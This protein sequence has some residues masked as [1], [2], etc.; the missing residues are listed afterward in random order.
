VLA[1]AAA[2]RAPVLAVVRTNEV[3]LVDTSSPLHPARSEPRA[4]PQAVRDAEVVAADVSPDG[5]LLAIATEA[6]N[7]VV[8]LDLGP[9]GHTPV[10]GML[11]VA[12][13]VRESVLADLAF[14]PGGDTLWVLS[15]DTPRS[16]AVGP[17]P[18]ELR[19]VRLRSDAQSMANLTAARVVEVAEAAA[20]VRLGVGRA[21]PLASG[22]AIRLPPERNT[23]FFAATAHPGSS[24][25]IFRVGAE[26]A[27]TVA[28]SSPS[29]LGR[30]DI[31]PEGRWLL[32]PAEAPDG[33][34]HVLAAAIDGRPAPPGAARPVAVVGPGA[35][36]APPAARPAPELRIQP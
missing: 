16:A 31:S 18:T 20:P 25:G 3:V 30:P 14:A 12:P 13:Q 35:G 19:A 2:A 22:A 28:I 21:L 17:E 5:K 11:A 24:N 10:A 23:V 1:L 27:A 36:E 9:A 15:G 7:Q 8:M 4:F 6:G 34:V 32:A 33:S 26:D 29:R